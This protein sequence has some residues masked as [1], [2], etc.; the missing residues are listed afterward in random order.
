MDEVN[1]L[2]SN[3]HVSSDY[4]NTL[5]RGTALMVKRETVPLISKILSF[6]INT[7]TIYNVPLI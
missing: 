4:V 6:T 5:L 1:S 2:P 3:R 7:Y